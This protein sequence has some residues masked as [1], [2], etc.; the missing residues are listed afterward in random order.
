LKIKRWQFGKLIEIEI[1]CEYC[2][3]PNVEYLHSDSDPGGYWSMYK[4]L[5]CDKEFADE[6][7][8]SES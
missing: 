5:N 4:C 8:G 1:V 3:S 7:A 2:N 6:P